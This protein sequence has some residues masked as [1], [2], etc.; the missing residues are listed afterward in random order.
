MKIEFLT[1]KDIDNIEKRDECYRKIDMR[2]CIQEEIITEEVFC[3]LPA[4]YDAKEMENSQ[5]KLDYIKYIMR[6]TEKTPE[7]F[8]SN[9][10]LL[11]VSLLG[12]F[13]GTEKGISLIILI[14]SIIFMVFN[15]KNLYIRGL[16]RNNLKEYNI[17]IRRL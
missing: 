15:I 11:G 17:D 13:A 1:K 7:F 4:G 3:T 6:R 5:L 16:I 8:I 9:V 10:L 14:L 2:L 12:L